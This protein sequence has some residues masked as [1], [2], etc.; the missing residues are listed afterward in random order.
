[1]NNQGWC[2]DLIQLSPNGQLIVTFGNS[3]SAQLFGPILP[4]NAWI[5]IALTYSTNNIL[6]LYINGTSYT[7]IISTAYSASGEVNILT[8]GNPSVSCMNQSNIHNTFPGSIDEFRVYSRELN[9]V[10]IR[11]LAN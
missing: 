3:A 2:Q 11:T 9:L 10:D 6:Q 5:H 1:M 7:S 4:L 8:L